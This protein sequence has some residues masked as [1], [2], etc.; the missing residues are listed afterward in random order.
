[1]VANESW[2]KMRSTTVRFEKHKFNGDKME[3]AEVLR[4][5]V[6]L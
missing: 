3:L 2:Q 4:A 6:I 5:S 1:M